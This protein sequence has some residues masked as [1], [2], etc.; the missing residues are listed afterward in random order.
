MER[1][2]QGLW[3][4]PAM[5]CN[6]NRVDLAIN[7]YENTEQFS[8]M[9]AVSHSTINASWSGTALDASWAM[10]AWQGGGGKP[11]AVG[12]AKS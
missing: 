1:G 5:R 11:V 8:P 9:T 4:E 7:N 10:W 2:S 3:E 12:G 6:P